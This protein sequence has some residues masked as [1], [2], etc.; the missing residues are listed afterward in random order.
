MKKPV[1]GAFCC[2]CGQG[3]ILALG[4]CATCYSL[5]RQDEEYFGGLR[6]DVLRR[7]GYL[8]RGCHAP[9]NRKRSIVVHH[10]R[11]G[12]SRMHLMIS[13]CLRCHAIVTRTH[14]MRRE[15]P[16]LLLVL[17]REQHPDGLEQ[18]MLNF[19][20]LLPPAEAVR[21]FPNEAMLEEGLNKRAWK[22]LHS[23]ALTAEA[24]L[25][26]ED[27]GSGGRRDE[28]LPTIKVA[29]SACH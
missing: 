8:C 24:R 12:D 18:M 17:W 16:V 14:W 29:P 9:G 5:K 4:L 22:S 11:P 13:L 23:A 19:R 28:G 7:D 2:P 1:Q 15:L 21:L 26:Q 25:S 6:E 3:K 27:E 10:R 20:V